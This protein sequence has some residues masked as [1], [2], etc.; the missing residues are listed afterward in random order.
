MKRHLPGPVE[1]ALFFG[2]AVI[3]AIV[4]GL[5]TH[6]D[7]ALF[8]CTAPVV[9]ISLLLG[10]HRHQTAGQV[11]EPGDEGEPLL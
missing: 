7:T 5:S 4:V 2:M 6:R 10:F 11:A 8:I 9:F 1:L 3:S